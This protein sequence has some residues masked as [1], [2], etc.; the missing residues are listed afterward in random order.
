MGVHPRTL[1][2]S[3]RDRARE[4]RAAADTFPFDSSGREWRIGVA[5]GYEQC[6][7]ALEEAA[8][9]ASERDITTSDCSDIWYGFR[10]G[11]LVDEYESRNQADR[12]LE[13]REVQMIAPAAQS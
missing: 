6:A 11:N 10:D 7:Q 4:V 8:D 5:L 1:A 13:R 3:W 9:A 12:A 2:A